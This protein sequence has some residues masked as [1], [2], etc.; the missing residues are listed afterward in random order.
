MRAFVGGE[1]A[2]RGDV[3]VEE[4]VDKGDGG[5]GDKADEEEDSF[6]KR[7]AGVSYGVV[8]GGEG[9]SG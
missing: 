2:S 9:W 5:D 1:E 3:V 7:K 6:E 8:R 4:P